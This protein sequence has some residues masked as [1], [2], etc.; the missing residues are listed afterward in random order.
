MYSPAL[1]L[2]VVGPF[3]RRVGEPLRSV[4]TA[5]GMRALL[6]KHGF[7]GR[8]GADRREGRGEAGALMRVA[9]GRGAS[10]TSAEKAFLCD[11]G[12]V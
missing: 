1:M 8:A 9:H 11:G 12:D 3:V 6:V 10:G 2:R 7:G 5:D 4:F